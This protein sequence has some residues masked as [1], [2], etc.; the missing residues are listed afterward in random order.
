[1]DDDSKSITYATIGVIAILLVAGMAVF[2]KGMTGKIMEPVYGVE[3]V[4]GGI[5]YG[6]EFPYLVKRTSGGYTTG[7]SIPPAGDGNFV[8]NG[9]YEQNPIPVTLEENMPPQAESVSGTRSRISFQRQPFFVPS[10]QICANAPGDETGFRCP[11]GSIC[12]EN[13]QMLRSEN[14]VP[15]PAYPCFKRAAGDV[16]TEAGYY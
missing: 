5:N 16:P 4:Y 1:M 13:L 2:L 12:V 8:P 3:R 14:W 7:G 11:Q 10:G 6:E 15:A 9:F